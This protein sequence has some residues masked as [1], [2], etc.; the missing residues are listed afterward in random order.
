MPDFYDTP[1]YSTRYVI[2]GHFMRETLAD[3]IREENITG[4]QAAMR[5]GFSKSFFNALMNGKR[6]NLGAE[7][8]AKLAAVTGRKMEDFIIRIN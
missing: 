2:D 1:N 3:Y 4:L 6:L 7:K 5:M 8:L